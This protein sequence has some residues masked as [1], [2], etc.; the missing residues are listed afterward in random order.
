MRYAFLLAAV[1]A[2]PAVHAQPGTLDST[3]GSGDGFVTFDV[4]GSYDSFSELVLQPDGKAAL[5]GSAY[6]ADGYALALA[7]F[8][9]DGSQPDATF[10]LGGRVLVLGNLGS[11]YA[12]GH[13]AVLQPDG[14]IVVGGADDPFGY[15][16]SNSFL[17]RF[18]A[19]GSLDPS[20]GTDGIVISD[21]DP[22]DDRLLDL[23]LLPDGRILS[24]GFR[25]YSGYVARYLPSG[26]LDRTFGPDGTGVVNRNNFI[27]NVLTFQSD[28]KIVLLGY[29]NEDEAIIVRLHADGA[30]DTGF[31]DEGR[32]VVGTSEEVLDLELRPDGYLVVLLNEPLGYA[33]RQ[34]LPDGMPD[35]A[36]G[37]GDGDASF[38]FFGGSSRTLPFSRTAAFSLL[39]LAATTL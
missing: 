13:A 20:F 10:G 34:F 4:G 22:S 35:A 32:V 11:N 31:G 39:A 1:L 21:L 2:A 7:R 14:K 3:F 37:E 19:D 5:V 24:T 8:L 33:L 17:A 36:F 30:V 12:L 23:A 27:T 9:P 15:Y 25:Y 16:N 18:L 26:R 28:G 6:G 29:E 38:D